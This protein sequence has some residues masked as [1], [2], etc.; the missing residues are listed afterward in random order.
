MAP[1]GEV[2]MKRFSVG[3]T[4]VCHPEREMFVLIVEQDGR[5]LVRKVVTLSALVDLIQ[6]SALRATST[7]ASRTTCRTSSGSPTTPWLTACRNASGLR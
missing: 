6:V 4:V 7:R 1:Q 2:K 3:K 5:Y